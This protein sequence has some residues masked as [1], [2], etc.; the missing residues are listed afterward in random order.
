MIVKWANKS[1]T[2]AIQLLWRWLRLEWIN[3]DWFRHVSEKNENNKIFELEKL[4]ISWYKT[5]EL[6]TFLQQ[7]TWEIKVVKI[8]KTEYYD[9]EHKEKITS[10]L[11]DDKLFYPKFNKKEETKKWWKYTITTEWEWQN[12]KIKVNNKFIKF[13]TKIK[14][15]ILNIKQDRKTTDIDLNYEVKKLDFKIVK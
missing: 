9:D 1:D 14:Y 13:N 15:N 2:T 12:F 7:A 8:H 6:E 10:L 11:N 3:W 5:A 4:Y